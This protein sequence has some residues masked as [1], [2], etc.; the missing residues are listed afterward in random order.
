MKTSFLFQAFALFFIAC[1]DPG[2]SGGQDDGD[3]DQESSGGSTATGGDSG[4]G[5]SDGGSG[6]GGETESG[7]G[8]SAGGNSGTGGSS[9][10]GST[11]G[12]S[13]GGSNPGGS[14]PGG[15]GP[16]GSQNADGGA[17]GEIDIDGIGKLCVDDTCPAGLTPTIIELCG[18]ASCTMGCACHLP[19][20]ENS[21]ICPEGTECLSLSD[22]SVDVCF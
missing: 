5:G 18:S 17:Q 4:V 6:S 20:E 13:T 7:G 1:G 21:T 15:S 22:V 3:G 9:T 14:G 11:G 2:D 16:G 19:C 10:G 8:P 12:S